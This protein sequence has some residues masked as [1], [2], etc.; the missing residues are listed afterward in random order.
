MR[1][2]SA[3]LGPWGKAEEGGGG[4]YDSGNSVGMG[5]CRVEGIVLEREQD[6]RLQRALGALGVRRG[7]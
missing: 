4:V 1:V 3:H 5:G 7:R 2:C 6:A